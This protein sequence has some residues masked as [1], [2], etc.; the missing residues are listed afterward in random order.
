[1]ATLSDP[2]I[3]HARPRRILR[4]GRIPTDEHDH[5]QAG[6]N[7]S[8]SGGGAWRIMMWRVTENSSTA[9]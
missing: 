8:C 4:F 3:A 9:S 1:M 5:D 7:P 6:R 2:I